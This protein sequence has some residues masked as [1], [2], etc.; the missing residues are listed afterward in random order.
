MTQTVSSTWQ[1]AANKRIVELRASDGGYLGSFGT[2][3]LHSPQGVAVDPTSGNIWVSDTSYNRL[4]EFDSTGNFIQ[5][6]GK[7]G[8]GNG[9]FNH[10]THLDVHVDATGNAYLYIADVFNDRIEILDLNENSP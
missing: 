1:T 8:S 4:V 3:N 7:A 6:F 10:P 9:Q 2:G 5:A